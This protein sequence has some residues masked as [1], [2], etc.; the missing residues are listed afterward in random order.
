MYSP[1][2]KAKLVCATFGL[3]LIGCAGHAYYFVRHA[4]QSPNL[5]GYEKFGGLLL[6]GFIVSL[7]PYWLSALIIAVGTE[8]FIP[9]IWPPRKQP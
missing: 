5:Y 3:W 4:Q 1:S 9:E 7:F 2:V 8:V 6:T